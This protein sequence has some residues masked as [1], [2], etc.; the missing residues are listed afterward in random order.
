MIH[1][2]YD[3]NLPGT[4]KPLGRRPVGRRPLNGSNIIPP[5]CPN[6]SRSL[7]PTLAGSRSG[8]LYIY[9]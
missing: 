8:A 6:G 4:P 9:K 2:T 3:G 5:P 1:A 7:T